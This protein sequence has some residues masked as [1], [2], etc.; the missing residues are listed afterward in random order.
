MG[1]VGYGHR[2]LTLPD[3]TK[4]RVIR[5]GE[6]NI[7]EI[8]TYTNELEGIL[9]LVRMYGYCFYPRNGMAGIGWITNDE[10]EV[11]NN[12][13]WPLDLN[14]ETVLKYP[15]FGFISHFKDSERIENDK[16]VKPR[17]LEI[18]S[19]IGALLFGGNQFAYDS[20]SNSVYSIIHSPHGDVGLAVEYIIDDTLSIETKRNLAVI[21]PPNT[22]ESFY[23]PYAR[24]DKLLG[25]WKIS[26]YTLVHNPEYP[27]K[28]PSPV[29]I[30]LTDIPAILF[31]NGQAFWEI[32]GEGSHAI[33]VGFFKK[34]LSDEEVIKS[35]ILVYSKDLITTCTFKFIDG[36]EHLIGLGIIAYPVINNT[37]KFSSD[38]SSARL[39]VHSI[40]AS[41][42]FS[43]SITVKSN[44]KP[45]DR[46]LVEVDKEKFV[47]SWTRE[48][49]SYG[50]NMPVTN[51]QFVYIQN[52]FWDTGSGPNFG[53]DTAGEQFASDF[54][55]NDDLYVTGEYPF[56]CAY[57]GN[58]LIVAK[59]TVDDNKGYSRTTNKTETSWVADGPYH[60]SGSAYVYGWDSEEH[61]DNKT[62][63]G[64]KY[65]HTLTYKDKSMTVRE[66]DLERIVTRVLDDTRGEHRLSGGVFYINHLNTFKRDYKTN[67]DMAK[68]FQ[69]LDLANDVV[70]YA[71]YTGTYS[72]YYE[73]K[74]TWTIDRGFHYLPLIVD[75]E[76][77]AR[78]VSVHFISDTVNYEFSVG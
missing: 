45:G 21:Y 18:N 2:M 15:I 73:L 44:G 4:I 30:S 22:V 28:H 39:I 60:Y 66:Y 32:G 38:G 57:D 70:S 1:G 29:A 65:K 55:G 35:P 33:G 51:R 56:A 7:I 58:T 14:S 76:K 64:I 78:H 6:R 67:K 25:R 47:L 5:D 68:Y 62:I 13:E 23:M 41:Y 54:Y 74:E 72:Y 69:Y 12:I 24:F 52:F 36:E 37:V 20:D 34:V 59:V 61:T 40:S 10:R 8:S 63:E 49:S 77:R 11:V 48:R 26:A 43:F 27:L 3:G 19:R 42:L 53:I 71:E 75:P 50:H 17:T 9:K 16:R 31:L 46:F